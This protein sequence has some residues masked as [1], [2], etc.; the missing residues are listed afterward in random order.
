[1]I[2]YD[3][4]SRF[5]DIVMG[6]R[7]EA[8]AFIGGL[9]SQSK[10]Q[11]RTILEI[12]C[13]T[14]TIL[15]ALSQSYDATGVDR[16]RSMLALARK[17]LPHVRFHRQD[18]TR[19]QLGTR[20]DVCVSAF[21][22]INHLLRF[23][24][25]Q[26]VFRRVTAHLQTDGLFVFDV[27]T[28]GKLERLADGQPWVKRFDR[29]LVVIKVVNGRRGLFHWDIQIFEHQKQA[30]Y[31]LIEETIPEIA[32]PLKRIRE[33]LRTHFKNVTVIDPEGARP[34]D[35]SERLYFVC[36]RAGE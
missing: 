26:R 7:S 8:A 13:G 35:Q 15:G 31:K 23:S 12:G 9:I 2:P 25:W 33:S 16:S 1:M 28:V 32:F 36:H 21:D 11:A 10:P 17:R 4:F 19:F 18:M 30:A 27:N 24:D 34:T 14:G 6:D 20:F 3:R 29:D 5:Y 22:S